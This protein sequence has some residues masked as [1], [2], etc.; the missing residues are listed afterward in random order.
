M[1][2]D[3]FAFLALGLLCFSVVVFGQELVQETEGEKKPLP[4]GFSRIRLGMELEAVREE[5]QLDGNFA[6]RGEPDVSLLREPSEALIECDG[7]YYID[8]AAFQFSEG[9]LFSISLNLNPEVLSYYTVFRTLQEKYGEP[10]DLNP[11]RAIWQDERVH[12]ALERPLN[13]RYIAAPVLTEMRR[14]RRQE[15]SLQSLLRERFLEQF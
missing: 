14:E 8:R 6:Y 9:R 5:L 2:T 15:R 4:D 13:V 1:R 10:D 7:A 12:M 11:E 3:R